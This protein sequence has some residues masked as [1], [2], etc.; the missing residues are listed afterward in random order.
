[1]VWGYSPSWQRA[2][3]AWGS[4]TCIHTQEAEECRRD[5]HWRLT[6]CRS[7]IQV[8]SKPC[9]SATSIQAGSS[10][11]RV[12]FTF[13]LLWW[14][15]TTKLA[16]RLYLVLGFQ[17][18][19]SPSRCESMAVLGRHSGIKGPVTRKWLKWFKDSNV[20]V[21]LQ[22]CTS[23]KRLYLLNLPQSALPAVEDVVRGLRLC[24]LA[25]SFFFF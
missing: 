11:L 15:T 8:I 4:V 10:I 7:F 13:L 21:C 2:G 9:E 6:H 25:L 5:A 17:E 12:L 19:K 16:Y 24:G 20:K 14:N 18:G 23:F 1:M 22:W 3:G